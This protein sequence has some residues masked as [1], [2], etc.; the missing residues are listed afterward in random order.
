[1]GPRDILPGT[2]GAALAVSPRP[3]YALDRHVSGQRA[4]TVEQPGSHQRAQAI[5]VDH[6]QNVVPLARRA[7]DLP[8]RRCGAEHV[9]RRGT[10]VGEGRRRADRSGRAEVGRRLAAARVEQVAESTTADLEMAL[11]LAGSRHRTLAE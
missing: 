9:E 8:A 1:S 6:Q 2:R 4:D 5:P 3:R 7:G 10:A 11:A